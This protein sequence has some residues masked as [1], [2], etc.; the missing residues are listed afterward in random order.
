MILGYKQDLL[1]GVKSLLWTDLF[2]ISLLR[3]IPLNG[4]VSFIFYQ[5]IQGQYVQLIAGKHPTFVHEH[6]FCYFCICTFVSDFSVMKPYVVLGVHCT[7]W[8]PDG[9]FLT[10]SPQLG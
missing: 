2:N 9:F 1:F 6:W 5:G 3:K 10:Q 7:Y 4:Q 8:K